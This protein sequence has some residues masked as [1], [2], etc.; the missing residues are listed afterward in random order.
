MLKKFVIFQMSI[1]ATYFILYFCASMVQGGWLK[2]EKIILF[3][4]N[5]FIV[6]TIALVLYWVGMVY[7]SIKI[8]LSILSGGL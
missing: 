2:N 6:L 4:R 5:F 7:E 8:A 1:I 3:L